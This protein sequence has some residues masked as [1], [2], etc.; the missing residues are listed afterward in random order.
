MIFCEIDCREGILVAVSKGKYEV[1]SRDLV[2]QKSTEGVIFFNNL[3][4]DLSEGISEVVQLYL[5]QLIRLI[6]ERHMTVSSAVRMQSFCCVYGAVALWADLC[7]SSCSRAE[8]NTGDCESF[9]QAVGSC[10][11]DGQ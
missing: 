11:L 5:S 3:S 6:I 10:C 4:Q 2:L 7:P 9:Q 1:T 8:R